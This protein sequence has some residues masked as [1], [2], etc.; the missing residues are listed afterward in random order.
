[1]RNTFLYLTFSVGPSV[2][3]ERGLVTR[4]IE[5]VTTFFSRFTGLHIYIHWYHFTKSNRLNL[6]I[7]MSINVWSSQLGS[8]TVSKSLLQT[9]H[10][11]QIGLHTRWIQCWIG[12]AIHDIIFRNSVTMCEFPP[13][14]WSYSNHGIRNSTVTFDSYFRFRE[15][16]HV[17]EQAPVPS[18][19]PGTWKK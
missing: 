2:H 19:R 1:M 10:L 14:M 7:S 8:C 16:F 3:T 11:L 5:T 9:P 13:R 18:P 15:D 17:F 12:A 6:L 4:G